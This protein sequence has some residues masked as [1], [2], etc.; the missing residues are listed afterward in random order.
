M[1]FRF[2]FLI[3]LAFQYY[4]N[5]MKIVLCSVAHIDIPNTGRRVIANLEP[6]SSSKQSSYLTFPTFGV[7]SYNFSLI[8]QESKSAFSP[9]SALKLHFYNYLFF[10]YSFCYLRI[11]LKDYPCNS[12][13]CVAEYAIRIASILPRESD[14]V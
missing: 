5:D 10:I 1:S 12:I 8:Y 11:T 7:Q 4:E 2:F 3:I 9:K 6:V 13:V 14:N